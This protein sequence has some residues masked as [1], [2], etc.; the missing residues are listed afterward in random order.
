MC[1]CMCICVCVC[2]LDAEA[3]HCLVAGARVE[4]DQRAWGRRRQKQA[5]DGAA[6]ALKH[7]LALFGL[8]AAPGKNKGQPY[9]RVDVLLQPFQFNLLSCI[10]VSVRVDCLS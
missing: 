10:C 9:A 3:A 8:H 1:M 6:V 2:Y 7:R 5:V 4:A